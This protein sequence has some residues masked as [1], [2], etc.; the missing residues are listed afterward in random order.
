M[1]E[2]AKEDFK[3]DFI[4]KTIVQQ[5]QFEQW[6]KYF[7]F[8]NNELSEKWNF[9]YQDVFYT[10]FYELLTEGLIYANKVL[11]SLQKGQNS[12]K[13]DWYSKLIE[14]LNNIKSEF[15]EEEFDYIEYRRH[16]SCHIFQNK[17]EHIQEN[18]Q[19]RTERNGRKL[20][21]I[22]ISLKKLI[23]KHGSDKD[24]DVYINSKLQNKLTELYNVLTEIQ[25]KN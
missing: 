9:V 24:I 18:L 25:K 2:T 17:Y 12:N 4:K 22:N 15:T 6:L 11:E 14:E 20:Q 5:A 19:I 10:K 8:L 3:Q 7:F 13:L 23:S 21:D 1:D 16:N